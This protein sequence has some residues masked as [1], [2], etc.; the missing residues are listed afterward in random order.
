MCGRSNLSA[1]N[2]NFRSEIGCLVRLLL[3][4]K[5][6]SGPPGFR[7]PRQLK[8]CR[9]ARPLRRF[10]TCWIRSAIPAWSAC[11]AKADLEPFAGSTESLRHPTIRPFRMGT[12]PFE[13][14]NQR[15]A[16]R[17]SSRVPVN[18]VSSCIRRHVVS[19]ASNDCLLYTSP[20][21]RD[22]STSRMPSSA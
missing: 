7:S 9:P 12:S 19:D 1:D 21:P 18:G 10:C 6:R 15:D 14:S 20:S 22:L 3:N 11:R 13:R 5:K 4:R 8:A 2:I 16:S 17:S